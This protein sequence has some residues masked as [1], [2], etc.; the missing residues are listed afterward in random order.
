MTYPRLAGD[1]DA[2]TAAAV[3]LFIGDS[4]II[5]DSA[6]ALADIAQW[7]VCVLLNT[8][9]TP[10][11][12]ADHSASIPDKLVVAQVG[13]ASGKQCPYYSAA[14]LNHNMLVWPAGVNTYA[15]RKALVAGSMI[16]IG[17]AKPAST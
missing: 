1:R 7:Q 16:S 10:Y 8:G 2:T 15:L 13:V 14:K 5:T 17:H 9:V 11:V 6:P 12:V 3:G 4:P